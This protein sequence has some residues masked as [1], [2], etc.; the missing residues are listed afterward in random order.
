MYTCVCVCVLCVCVCVCGCVYE[1]EIYQRKYL[2][3]KETTSRETIHTDDC[4]NK[5][6]VNTKGL[7]IGMRVLTLIIVLK[8]CTYDC[9][10]SNR[11]LTT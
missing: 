2:A 5:Y 11:N 6:V 7:F 4:T 10:V 8:L 1:G 9:S 3:N